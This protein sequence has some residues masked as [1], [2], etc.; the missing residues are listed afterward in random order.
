MKVIRL[1]QN[2]IEKL[3]KKI[4]NES[5]RPR[6][7]MLYGNKAEII[8]EVVNRIGQYGDE[9]IQELESLNARFPSTKY[10]RVERP[11]KVEVPQGVKIKSTVYPNR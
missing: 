4:M 11:E 3:V 10:K 8:D 9:Y 7:G 2:D 6:G 5:E 1:N